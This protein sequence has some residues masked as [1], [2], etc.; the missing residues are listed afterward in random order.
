M[1]K[2]CVWLEVNQG[3]KKIENKVARCF[4]SQD[5]F[6]HLPLLRA[7]PLEALARKKEM[8]LWRVTRIWSFVC[9]FELKGIGFDSWCE[10]TRGSVF[11][12]LFAVSLYFVRISVALHGSHGNLNKFLWK[13]RVIYNHFLLASLLVVAC[14]VRLF[15]PT[16]W[17]FFMIG[18]KF[19]S[20]FLPSW[21]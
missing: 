5:P 21:Q 16:G 14:L 18:I 3:L 8:D 7:N 2:K 15:I 19:T 4:L 20:L 1:P 10:S 17:E 13:R 11:W 9:H 12:R 6:H